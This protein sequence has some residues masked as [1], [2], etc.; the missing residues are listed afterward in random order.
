[1]VDT[2]R[3][4]A[5]LLQSTAVSGSSWREH[6]CSGAIATFRIYVVLRELASPTMINTLIFIKRKMKLGFL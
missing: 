5:E 3:W 6:W 4:M 1:M 2:D